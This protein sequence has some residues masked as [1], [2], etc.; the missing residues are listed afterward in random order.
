MTPIP[1][2]KQAVDQ[3]DELLK[4]KGAPRKCY[5]L[6]EISSIDG[7]FM[8]LEE[9]LCEI[10][11]AG[12]ASVVSCLPGVLGFYEGEVIG[13]RWLLERRGGPTTGCS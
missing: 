10:V 6:S 1:K 13:E 12:L 9:A 2:G 8:A 7:T 3:I 11:G 5:V 4:Q